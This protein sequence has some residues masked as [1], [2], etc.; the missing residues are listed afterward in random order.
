MG[1][2][3]GGNFH[4]KL[5]LHRVGGG[6]QGTVA[7][8]LAGAAARERCAA[9]PCWLLAVGCCVA[10][11]EKCSGGEDGSLERNGWAETASALVASCLM[12]AAVG[13]GAGRGGR[14][15]IF[16]RA[17]RASSGGVLVLPWWD[18]GLITFIGMILG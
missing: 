13:V 4:P 10:A 14:Q 15:R 11:G 9:A 12:P 5:P 2:I 1:G 3:V 6:L 17:D 8:S 18:A 16:H 7:A